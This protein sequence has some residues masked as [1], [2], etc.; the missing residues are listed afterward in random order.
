M[1]VLRCFSTSVC[2]SWARHASPQDSAGGG[3]CLSQ[4]SSMDSLHF[5]PDVPPGLE[6]F[7]GAQGSALLPLPPYDF[8][9][10][11]CLT[12]RAAAAAPACMQQPALFAKSCVGVMGLMLSVDVPQ[13]AGR[14]LRRCFFSGGRSRATTR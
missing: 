7:P 3:S 6:A 10:A 11:P 2:R 1:R 14:L 4:R 12:V 5:F 13:L 9:P 8:R